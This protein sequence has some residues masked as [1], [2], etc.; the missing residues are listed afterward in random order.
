MT[1]TTTAR[2]SSRPGAA[3][4]AITRR[5][6]PRERADERTGNIAQRIV[7]TYLDHAD[8]LE[9]TLAL[10]WVSFGTT[11]GVTRF[12]THAIRG[13][14]LPFLH[15]VSTGGLHLHHYNFGIA[16]LGGV[17]LVA[18]RGN[19][20]AVGHPVVGVAYG[21]GCAL[22]ADEAA[23]LLDLKDV[24][25]TKKGALSVN[26]AVVTIATLGAYVAAAPFWDDA[27]RELRRGLRRL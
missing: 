15:N 6:R 24:Y 8:P 20:R 18:V 7:K 13:H 23:L 26:L 4:D 11:F 10:T 22:I 9:E 2:G 14:W 19:K 27:L 16:L 3:R 17:G 25:W 5:L 21:I 12:V 1:Q